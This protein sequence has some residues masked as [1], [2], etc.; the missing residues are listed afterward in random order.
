[1]ITRSCR[2]RTA[3]GKFTCPT[4][5]RR[6]NSTANGMV[7]RMAIV[8]STQG[9]ASRSMNLRRA[10]GLSID[11][12]GYGRWRKGTIASPLTAA[13]DQHKPRLLDQVREVMRCHTE[14]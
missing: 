14:K 13:S 1:M 8:L 11:H 7:A 3:R 10:I 9:I 5:Q 6:Y 12:P 2:P 4:T